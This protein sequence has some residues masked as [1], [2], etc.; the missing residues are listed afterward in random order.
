MKKIATLLRVTVMATIVLFCQ[1]LSAQT[2]KDFFSSSEVPLTYLG[3]DFTNA[4]VL[5]EISQN[6]MDIRD[7]HYVGINDL[8]LKEFKKYDIGK[9]FNKSLVTNDISQAKAK[10]AKID[11]EKIMESSA[12]DLRLKKAN[13]ESI[14]KGY[15]FSG[16]KGIGLLFIMETMNKTSEKGSMY[17]TL[18]DMASNKVLLT[19]RMT[20]AAGGIGF[21]NCWIK[22]IYFVLAEI[23]KSKYNEWKSANS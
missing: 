2:L 12:D 8:M 22:T 10:N 23:R 15:D 4:K 18:I 6:A 14:V 21:R 20:G 17:V 5:N 16:K 1:T 9:A 19:E 3:I 13:I 7:R 11:A